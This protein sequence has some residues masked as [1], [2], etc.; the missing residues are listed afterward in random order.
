MWLFNDNAVVFCNDVVIGG[1]KDFLQWAEREHGYQ[2]FQPLPL[3]TT[4][5]DESYKSHFMSQKVS[6]VANRCMIIFS[7]DLY[8]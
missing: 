7:I 2:S 4:L 6:Y 5:A 1:P 3:Y 8:S